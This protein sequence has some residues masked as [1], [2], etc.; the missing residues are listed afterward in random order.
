VLVDVLYANRLAQILWDWGDGKVVRVLRDLSR[1]AKSGGVNK[2][3]I[4]RWPNQTPNA[5]DDS[6]DGHDMICDQVTQNF[7]RGVV[8]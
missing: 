5:D 7:R 3:L 4:S 2:V 1:R 6:V 8:C